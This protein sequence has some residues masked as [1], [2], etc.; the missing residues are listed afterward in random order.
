MWHAELLLFVFGQ[1]FGRIIF[2]TTRPKFFAK[3]ALIFLFP[4]KPQGASHGRAQKNAELLPFSACRCRPSSSPWSSGRRRRPRRNA[5]D[6]SRVR[7][8]LSGSRN[9]QVVT[10]LGSDPRHL[11]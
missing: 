3:D 7:P 5:S 2:R 1:A 9:D 6:Q 8:L 11:S 4:N 10:R